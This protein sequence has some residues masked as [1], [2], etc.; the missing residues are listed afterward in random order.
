VAHLKR[1]I[2]GWHLAEL[3]FDG[4]YDSAGIGRTPSV[5]RCQE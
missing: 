2:Y 3:P 5:V 4:Q 1:G